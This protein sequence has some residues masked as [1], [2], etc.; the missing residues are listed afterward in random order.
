MTASVVDQVRQAVEEAR[1]KGEEPPGR[2]TL[3]KLT[4]ATDH[5]VKVAL[6][7]LAKTGD[8]EPPATASE[9]PPA[10]KFCPPV[11]PFGSEGAG[12]DT[13]EGAGN[14][15]ERGA[16]ANAGDRLATAGDALVAAGASAD[17]AGDSRVTHGI[18]G[19]K[20]VAWLGFAFGSI[21]SIGANVLAARVPPKDAPADWSPRLDSQ[22][23]AA[24]WPVALLL[25]VEVLSRIPWPDGRLWKFARYGGVGMV[26]LGSAIISYQHIRDVLVSWGYPLLSAA[27][28]P[29][30]IDGLMTASGFALLA[31][32]GGRLAKSGT[33]AGDAGDKAGDTR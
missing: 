24:V 12:Q 5:Q 8:P 20:L 33:N 9:R 29:L 19:G 3:I 6:A 26:A 10:F 1:R 32:A 21:V 14:E 7:T 22:V 28:G 13:P 27:V 2:P 25:S 11:R 31:S 17:D 16:L 23:G 30:V 15:P 18:R 4:G